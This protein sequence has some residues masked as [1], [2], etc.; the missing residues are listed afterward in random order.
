[1]CDMN[2]PVT[3]IQCMKNTPHNCHPEASEGPCIWL[4]NDSKI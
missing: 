2:Q 3:V 1:M 4:L